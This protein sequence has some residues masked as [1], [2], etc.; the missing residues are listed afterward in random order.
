MS[1]LLHYRRR[2]S[3]LSELMIALSITSTTIML[4]TGMLHTVF[5]TCGRVVGQ[6]ESQEKVG[7]LA[8]LLRSDMVMSHWV[9]LTEPEEQVAE[10][11]GEPH[12]VLQ[13]SMDPEGTEQCVYEVHGDVVERRIRTANSMIAT[14][15]FHLPRAPQITLLST[16]SPL[17]E[18]LRIRIPWTSQNSA[19]LALQ[20]PANFRKGYK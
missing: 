13:I 15:S 4:A 18:M 2:G 12:I 10:A 16:N 17:S 9:E 5:K 6:L 3:L 19:A 1:T 20:L 11:G 7:T 14:H 8:Q